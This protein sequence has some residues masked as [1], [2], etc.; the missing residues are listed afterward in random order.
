MGKCSAPCLQHRH[1]QKHLGL[2]LED[3]PLGAHRC[4]DKPGHP[5]A[6]AA[7]DSPGVSFLGSVKE[8]TTVFV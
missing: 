8:G 7:D 3:W 2:G 1:S 4:E 6:I 5:V